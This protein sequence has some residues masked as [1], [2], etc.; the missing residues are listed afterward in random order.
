MPDRLGLK[1]RVAIVTGAG[2][3]IGRAIAL[4]FGDAGAAV[5]VA[6]RTRGEVEV[7]ASLLHER[8]HRALPLVADVSDWQAV[9]G[10]VAQTVQ[11]FGGIHILVNNAGVQGSIG[12]LVDN[13]VAEWMC[14]VEINLGGTFLCCKAVLPHMMRQDYGT[15]INLSGGGA[16]SSRPY[17]SAYA[18]SKAA[19][20]RLT[21]T[22]SEEVREYN[23][24]VN[25]IAPGAVNTRMLEETMAAGLA[26]GDEAQADAKHQLKTGGNPPELAAR[27]AVFLASDDSD[28]LTGKLIAAP[29]DPW[30][31]WAGKAD[32]LNATPLYTIRRLDPFTIN[33]LIKDL[34]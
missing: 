29:Y 6:A 31:E 7:T 1:D 23:I 17:F 20:V 24:R 13:D 33:T 30:R 18:A 22:L 8:G 3:G 14:T 32:E 16:T 10:L 15:I 11:R 25:A 21:E 34:S 26:A 9:Q 4:A 5:T 27:L 12:P 28:G 19:V 2:R